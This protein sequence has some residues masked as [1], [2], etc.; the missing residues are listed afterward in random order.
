MAKNK[1]EFRTNFSDILTKGKE[2]REEVTL[3][4]SLFGN[5]AQRLKD[6]L[7]VKSCN[8]LEEIGLNPHEDYEGGFFSDTTSLGWAVTDKAISY[9]EGDVSKK[10]CMDNIM[11]IIDRFSSV[12]EE[13]PV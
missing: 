4:Q 10:E 9:T 8:A 7:F 2:N 5:K 11:Q 1:K 6:A 3:F 12:Q 13:Q